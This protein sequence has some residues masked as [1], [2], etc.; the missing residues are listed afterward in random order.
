VQAVVWH[1]TP[2][3]K[4]PWPAESTGVGWMVQVVPFHRSARVV[5]PEFDV[6]FRFP[7]AVQVAGVVQDTAARTPPGGGLGVGSVRQFVPFHRSASVPTGLPALSVRA[8]TAVQNE[9]EVQDTPAK[10][11]PGAP[12]GAGTG[13]IRHRVPSQRSATSPVG[14]PELSKDVP[15]A[16]QNVWAVQ[17]TPNRALPG[18]PAGLGVG[19]KVQFVPFHRSA[20]VPVGLPKLSVRVPTAVQ[21]TADVQDAAPRKPPPAGLGVCWMRHFTP[22]HRSASGR[23][24]DVPMA[25]QA[26][27]AVQDTPARTLGAAPVGLGVGWM[28]HRVPFHCSARAWKVPELLM[29]YP[30]AVQAEEAA[31]AT[32]IRKFGPPV[33]LGVGWMVH[34]VPFHCSARVWKVP[35]L[36]M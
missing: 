30:A 27:G 33:R 23:F 13:R 4:L 21:A 35:E 12:E 5:V 14:K 24:A 28:V 9:G 25:V 8:P 3:K 16:M 17:E 2:L 22:S 10:K 34:R 18:A 7:A 36:L 26:E 31:Q 15:T 6:A 19:W 1:A 32:P 11:L 29:E 20:R